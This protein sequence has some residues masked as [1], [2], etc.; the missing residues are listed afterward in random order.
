VRL[1][2]GGQAAVAGVGLPSGF[3]EKHLGFGHSTGAMDHTFGDDAHFARA[4]RDGVAIFAVHRDL[5]LK[6]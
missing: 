4:K 5:A 2:G 1:L 3:N 6:D